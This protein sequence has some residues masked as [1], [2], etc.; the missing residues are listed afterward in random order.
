[1]LLRLA[2]QVFLVLGGEVSYF[3]AYYFSL[4]LFSLLGVSWAQGRP[5]VAARSP[6]EGSWSS[7]GGA[8]G[9]SWGRLGGR[10]RAPEGVIQNYWRGPVWE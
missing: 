1:M 6:L 8:L 4:E 2:C 3:L 9:A 5:Q 7:L 10:I